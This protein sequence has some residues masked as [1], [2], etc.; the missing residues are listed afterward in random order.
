MLFRSPDRDR[1]LSNVALYWFTR[2]FPTSIYV[3]RMV[4]ENVELLMADWKAIQ[5]PLG[6]SCFKN[7]LSTPP[8]RWIKQT[9]QVKWYRI[10]ER[11]G[12]FPALEEPETLWR[13]VEAFIGEF[14]GKTD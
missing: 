7:D 8:E 14:W 2:S 1:I 4:F 3:H 5:K 10:H 13:D 12:H 11:G 9:E 6:Y